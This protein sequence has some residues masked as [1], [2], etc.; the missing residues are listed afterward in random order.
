MRFNKNRISLLAGI[1]N[2]D[3]Y[4]G[5]TL[6][7]NYAPGVLT[8]AEDESSE[9]EDKGEDTPV[10]VKDDAP[11][12]DDTADTSATEESTGDDTVSKQDVAVALAGVLGVDSDAM[13]ALVAGEKEEAS[14]ESSSAESGDA[15]AST[16]DSKE[17]ALET[18]ME[19]E[20]HGFYEARLRRV[21]RAELDSIIKES[22][23]H[24]HSIENQIRRARQAKSVAVAL[25]YKK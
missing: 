18:D 12:S 24:G 5:K 15:E 7:E 13:T 25:G 10:E 14:D 1:D 19:N 6:R 16:D 8:E 3:Q 23:G 20:V 17:L 21:I 4:F 2:R 11:A 22:R 9:S